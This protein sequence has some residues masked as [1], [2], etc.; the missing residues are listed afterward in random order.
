MDSS[1]GN[2]QNSVPID[3]NYGNAY[4]FYEI[5]YL[6]IGC[7][8]SDIGGPQQ[9]PPFL[10]RLMEL[11]PDW[12]LHLILVDPE[13]ENPP[14]V[15]SLLD[16]QTANRTCLTVSRRLF[17][18]QILEDV[19][20]PVGICWTGRA[21]ALPGMSKFSRRD[22]DY[23]VHRT[24]DSPIPSLFMAHDFT[25]YSNSTLSNRFRKIYGRSPLYRHRCLVDIGYD[26][27][28]GCFFD[29]SLENFSPLLYNTP[30][31]L[32]NQIV[33]VLSVFDPR[34]LSRQEMLSIMFHQPSNPL[35]AR[36]R[37][38]VW[39]RIERSFQGL[40]ESL[41]SYRHLRLCLREGRVDAH[42]RIDNVLFVSEDFQ[43]PPEQRL[44][45]IHQRLTQSLSDLSFFEPSL[46]IVSD[47]GNY[48]QATD[49]NP[50]EIIGKYEE[51][52][53]RLKRHYYSQHPQYEI[54]SAHP[55][56]PVGI[57]LNYQ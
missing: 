5:T 36:A 9:Y 32:D 8:H 21:D 16:H 14:H 3:G 17:C 26:E 38:L 44:E 50:Y 40:R 37:D 28:T 41:A 20:D 11:R 55:N 34:D 4:D 53:S 47:F 33:P 54:I 56:M 43:G 18:H 7:Y 42:I 15:T 49:L 46:Q 1:R 23:L 10:A 35:L 39:R 57:V 24:L 25:G 51:M 29:M 52:I 22:V 48:C 19:S 12:H 13:L 45:K 30:Q 27:E 2:R 6:A 31:N